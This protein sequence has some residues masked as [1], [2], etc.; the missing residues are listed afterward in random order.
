MHGALAQRDDPGGDVLPTIRRYE[1][2]LLDLLAARLGMPV[3]TGW[4]GDLWDRSGRLVH[5]FEARGPARLATPDRPR[6]VWA[7]LAGKGVEAAAEIASAI[8]G[9]EA[10]LLARF[11]ESEAAVGKPAGRRAAVRKGLAAATSKQ[12]R[13]STRTGTLD[14]V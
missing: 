7:L 11:L 4:L 2:D 12:T 8:S 3:V 5:F 13:T 6:L 10:F 1:R 9:L 14:D